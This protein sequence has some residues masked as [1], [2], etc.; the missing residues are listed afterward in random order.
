M[1][2]KKIKINVKVR[3]ESIVFELIKKLKKT[4]LILKAFFYRKLFFYNFF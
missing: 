3:E 1:L 4:W 2:E